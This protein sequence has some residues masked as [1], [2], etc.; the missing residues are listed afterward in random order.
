MGVVKVLYYDG[1]F[2]NGWQKKENNMC[3]KKELLIKKL[4][5]QI[6]D[7]KEELREEKI[8]QSSSCMY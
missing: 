6:E 8:S 1:V 5:K 2:Y 4:L 3:E 7:L